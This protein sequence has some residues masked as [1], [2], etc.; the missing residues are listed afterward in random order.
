M[1]FFSRFSSKRIV[2]AKAVLAVFGL[3]LVFGVNN[4]RAQAI[5]EDF[6]NITTLPAAGWFTQ[7]KQHPIAPPVGFKNSAVFPAQAG[8]RPNIG[9][10]FNNTTARTPQQWL[11][12]PNDFNNGDVISLATHHPA[13]PFPD[14]LK[15]AVNCWRKH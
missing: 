1:K 5:T 8:R 2:R 15:F 3:F 14:R 6:V 11:L 7:N 12:A 9:A 4:S 13:K 10:H